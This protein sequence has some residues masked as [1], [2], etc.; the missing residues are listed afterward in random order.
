MIKVLVVDDSALMRKL[1]GQV[2]A[3][4]GDF[5]MQTARNGVEAL[6]TIERFR[7]DVVTL[8]VQ[9]PEMDGL[10]C[11]NRIMLEHPCPVVMVSALT[12][13][14]AEETLSALALGAIDFIPKP[15]GAISL[16]LEEFGPLILER[17]RAAAAIGVKRSR[18]LAERLRHRAQRD[19]LR[20]DVPRA[21]TP[22]TTGSGLVL[23]GC[24]TG[25]PP[26]LDALLSRLPAAFPLPILIAQH[27]PASFTGPLAKRLSRLCA[28]DVVE[29]DQL[30]KLSAGAAYVG[31]GDADLMVTRRRG[32]LVAMAIPSEAKYRWHPSV[33]RLVDSA[34]E[35]VSASQLVGILMTGMGDDGA[36]AMTRL[37]QAGGHTIAEARSTAI[38]WGMPGSLVQMG[39][40]VDTV[41]LDRIA[42]ALMEAVR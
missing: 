2:F 31:K 17:V 28:I 3:A 10:A 11:L 35:N 38:V 23:V 8:D 26:A 36:A 29:V 15:Q 41:P 19:E 12:A 30:L 22:R 16:H 42:A 13:E 24:S 7:P 9:M 20:A 14:G 25:G 21:V 39:G 6:E 27:M 1:L 18:R 40:A 5:V 32:E 33:D 37:R 4:A 34:M